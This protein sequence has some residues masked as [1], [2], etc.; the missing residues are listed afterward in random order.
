M[1]AS[2]NQLSRFIMAAARRDRTLVLPRGLFALTLCYSF[3]TTF[4]ILRGVERS[5]SRS[6]IP[7]TLNFNDYVSAKHVRT[8]NDVQTIFLQSTTSEPIQLNEIEVYSLGVNVAPSG[9]ASQSST[10]RDHG[11]GSDFYGAGKAIDLDNQTFTHTN[12]D[13][14]WLSIDLPNPV[15]V[16]SIRIINRSCP[17]EKRRREQQGC[18]CRLSYAN[19][20]L[21]NSNGDTLATRALGNTCGVQTIVEDYSLLTNRESTDITTTTDS[22]MKYLVADLQGGLTNQAIEIW[23]A[24]LIAQ[25]L[26]RTLV[27]P[28]ILVK[29]PLGGLYANRKWTTPEPFNVVWDDKF[30]VQCA[31][32]KLNRPD[33]LVDSE[34]HHY[35]VRIKNEHRYTVSPGHSVNSIAPWFFNANSSQNTLASRL[36]KDDSKYVRIVNPYHYESSRKWNYAE[37]FRPSSILNKKIQHYQSLLPSNYSCLHARTEQ[38]WYS[39]E[40]CKEGAKRNTTSIHPELWTCEEF[41][42]EKCYSTPTEIANLL[43]SKLALQSPLWVSSG[44]SH[45]SL[46]LIYDS[47]EVFTN[48]DIN[49]QNPVF[50]DYSVAEIDRAVCSGASTFWGMRRSTFSMVL[51]RMIR[52]RGGKTY[53][54]P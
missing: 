22:T 52:T 6:N 2:A 13:N 42:R 38:D 37:C 19:L 14:A 48:K 51:E 43:K 36:M 32:N 15:D 26:N 28:E 3:V 45:E 49:A 33:V 46:Q 11:K 40:C 16:E 35:A 31:R 34:S 25:N 23:T 9:K 20:V 8:I 39:I 44:S 1:K 27:L 29:I 21:Q 41:N 53:F 5:I 7:S 30:F 47:F 12:D 10:L 18:M 17:D 54:Y 24:L 4:I 50:M